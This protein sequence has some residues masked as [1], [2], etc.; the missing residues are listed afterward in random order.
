MKKNHCT[1]VVELSY[2]DLVITVGEITLGEENR[3]KLQKTQRMKEKM[4]LIEAACALLNSG[5]GV[6]R[7]KMANKDEHPVEM[8]LD[9]EKALRDLIQSLHLQAFF[10]KKQE[11]S[12]VYIFVKSW[13]SDPSPDDS[14]MP[15]ICSLSSSLYVR[16]G[17]SVLCMDSIHA[18]K[19]LKDKKKNVKRSNEGSPPTNI[20]RAASSE[21]EMI[22]D[23]FFLKNNFEHGEILPFPESECTEFKQFSTGNIQKYLRDI[24]PEY[25]SAFA[26]TSGGCLFI[27]VD[28]KTKKV[29]GCPKENVDAGSLRDSIASAISKLPIFHFCSSKPSMDDY[30]ETKVVDVFQQGKLYGYLCMIK[31]KPFCCM[32]FSEAPSSWVVKG[33]DIGLLTVKEWVHKMIDTDTETELTEAFKCQLNISHSPPMCRPVY[34]KKGLEHKQDLQKR[35]FQVPSEGLQYTPESL[36]EELC[37]EHEGLKELM[38]KHMHPFSQG[39]LILS[40]SWA[41]DMDL[42]EQQGVICDAL[43]IAQNSFPILYTILAEQDEEGQHNCIHTA[44]TLKQK[45]VN[46]GGYTGRL[47]IMTKVLRL[48]PEKNAESLKG[49]S[50]PI[51]YP[52][53]YRLADTQQMDN[54]LQSLVIVLL[55]FRSFLSDKLG[56]EILNLLTHQQY[57]ILS[58]NL[59]KNKELFIHGLPG[60]GKTVMAVKI[61]QKIRNVFHCAP[62]K[63]LYICENQPLRDFIGS[64]NICCA[65]TRKKFMTF[66]FDNIQH[67]IVDEAQNFRTE[68]GNWYAKAKAITQR[69]QDC[70]GILWIFLD[71]YQTTHKFSTG[72]PPPSAQNSKEELTRVVRNADP[73]GYYLQKVIERVK[74][75]PPANLPLE[76]LEMLHEAEWAQGVSGV[77]EI[78]NFLD[79][80]KIMA[81]IAKQCQLFFRKGYSAKDIAVL[82]N[83]AADVDEYTEILQRSMR[84]RMC[85]QSGEN[86]AGLACFGD[87]SRVMEDLI[88]VDSVRRFSGLERNIVF[89]INPQPAEPVLCHSL[90]LCL[91]SRAKKHLYILTSN[92]MSI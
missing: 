55:G 92:Y 10:E 35:L 75:N 26:N 1:L 78:K 60:T 14:S 27:G 52:E 33:R 44:F 64:K 5:G 86:C 7:V 63:I 15:R 57:E 19:F 16:S 77:C 68:D 23:E 81:Y 29:L 3:N 21:Y 28:D 50:S 17:T 53:S 42:P 91:A 43:L 70:P 49:S 74:E 36:W 65:V 40:R 56:R 38:Y 58:K 83:T 6:I 20:L 71:Y 8:G 41:V 24:I 80:Q 67:I 25:V 34:S 9:L 11:E 47:C 82:L 39:V 48:G 37:S 4:T 59:R 62:E 46:I 32:V 2:P 18:F 22:A 84:K 45:L 13:S 12:Y 79:I 31:V 90:L 66:D 89:G 54:L 30:F 76:S 61:M 69:N 85:H 51:V 88:V 72:L 73:I 87:A